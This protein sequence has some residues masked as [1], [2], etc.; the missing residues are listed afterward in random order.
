MPQPRSEL[1]VRL[2][3]SLRNPRVKYLHSLRHRKYRR[4]EGRFLIEGIRIVEEALTC[5]APLETLVYAPQLLV[6]DRAH[7]LVQQVDPASRLA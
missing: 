6:S 3:T 1:A 4:R 2:I 7:D 5:H